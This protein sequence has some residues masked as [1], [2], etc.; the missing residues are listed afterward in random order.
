MRYRQKSNFVQ[1]PLK[2]ANDN[3][4]PIRQAMKSSDVGNVLSQSDYTKPNRRLLMVAVLL[5]IAA[6]A[7]FCMRLAI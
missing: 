5:G 3:Y 7:A 2:P 6:L 1:A 4:T